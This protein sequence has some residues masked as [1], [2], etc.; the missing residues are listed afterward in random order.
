[1]VRFV[2]DNPE[3][4]VL[5][6]M[7][8]GA[9]KTIIVLVLGMLLQRLAPNRDARILVV[10]PFTAV[11]VEWMGKCKHI[12]NTN[13]IQRL[14]GNGDI[15]PSARI[16]ITSCDSLTTLRLKPIFQMHGNGIFLIVADEAH[17]NIEDAQ[18]YRPDLM[19]V[20]Y[21]PEFLH[22]P[23]LMMSGTFPV[24]LGINLDRSLGVPRIEEFR[25]STERQHVRL[26]MLSIRSVAHCDEVVK[27]LIERF[28]IVENKRMMIF[29]CS[30]ADAEEWCQRYSDLTTTGKSFF[31]YKIYYYLEQRVCHWGLYVRRIQ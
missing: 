25:H 7:P 2:W 16:L 13:F 10:C 3:C 21:L 27:Q 19:N 20:G 30:K 15:S 12:S 18:T 14:C 4:S 28:K 24:K 17:S 1:M 26:N 9:G 6:V 11:M 29:V 8:C 23:I 31:L 22:R 5:C